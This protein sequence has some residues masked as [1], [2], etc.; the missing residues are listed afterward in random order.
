LLFSSSLC[1]ASS[2][3]SLLRCFQLHHCSSLHQYLYFF[4]DFHCTVTYTIGE[5]YTYT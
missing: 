4:I 1:L 3:L 5:S 2:L